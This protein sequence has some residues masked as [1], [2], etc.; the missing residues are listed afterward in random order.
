MKKIILVLCVGILFSLQTNA[1]G[2]LNKLGNA[3]KDAAKR[4]V[5]NRVED[6]ADEVTKKAMSG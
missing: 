1:Q 5:E 3:A 4:A 6:K 2:W